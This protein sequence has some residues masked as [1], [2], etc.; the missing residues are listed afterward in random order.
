MNVLKNVYRVYADHLKD[1]F[2]TVEMPIA[3]SD[4]FDQKMAAVCRGT[5]GTGTGGPG[6]GLSIGSIGASNGQT[7]I[8]A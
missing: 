3:R 7:G 4:A 2:Y 5:A 6:G 1:P 8:G